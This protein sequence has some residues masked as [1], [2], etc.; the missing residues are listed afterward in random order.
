MH[1]Y[2]LTL[3]S[4]FL[5]VLT[6]LTSLTAAETAF[7]DTAT[8]VRLKELCFVEGVRDNQLHGVGV[9]TGLSGTGDKGT[10]AVKLLQSFV[11]K[12]MLRVSTTDLS[13]KNIALVAITA[14][15]PPFMK[16]GAELTATISSIG[17]A[18]SLKGGYLMQTLLVGADGNVYAAAQGSL[19]VGGFGNAGP[20]LAPTGTSHTNIET[21]AL[22]ENGAIVET[23]LPVDLTIGQELRLALKNPD[24]VTASRVAH[25]VRQN[26]SHLESLIDDN[27]ILL[28]AHDAAT[29]GLLFDKQPSNNALVTLIAELEALRVTP[30]I[31]AR[32]VINERTGTIVVGADVRISPAAVSHG[33]LSLQVRSRREI[34]ADPNNPRERIEEM[35]WN[36]QV[37]GGRRLNGKP[38]G[39]D[40]DS[41]SIPGTLS[42][43]DG[44]TVKDISNALN[45]LGARPRDVIAIFQALHRAGAL[46]A[47]VVVM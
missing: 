42:V 2:T 29:V 13:S 41:E 35:V 30:D 34:T 10:A 3:C 22:L 38:A 44:T 14:K 15:L 7:T 8:G 9:V 36:D 5:L 23:E 25:A 27:T 45:A 31:P 28:T 26:L 20:G 12:N 16:K 11:A 47:E 18:T 1:T 39:V 32:I 24:F 40:V 43:L 33:G 6:F 37:S 4:S 21:I 17:D 46:H 19:S